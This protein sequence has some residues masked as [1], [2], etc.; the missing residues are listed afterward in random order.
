MEALKALPAFLPLPSPGL[1][2]APDT[3]F[4]PFSLFLK[5]PDVPPFT[6]CRW[7]ERSWAQFAMPAGTDALNAVCVTV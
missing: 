7:R 4:S 6:L 5:Q 3:S 2:N 1:A